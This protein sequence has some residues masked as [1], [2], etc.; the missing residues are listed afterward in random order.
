MG[1]QRDRVLSSL[2]TKEKG[3]EMR[4]WL[5][6]IVFALCVAGCTK[7]IDNQGKSTWK[8][9][10]IVS[11][12]VEQPIEATGN[13]LTALSAVYP[14]AG[15]AGVALLTALGIYR[16]KIKPNFEKAQTEAN[17]YHTSTHTLVQVIETIK[18]EQ[19]GAWKLIEPFLKSKMGQNTE[20]VIR[21]LRGLPPKE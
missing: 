16:K 21:A 5:I 12:K 11:E 2:Q 8:I 4:K 14:P 15:A 13:L 3:D 1:R 10:P 20:N 19:P 17:L 7:E 18:K 9:N 6:T